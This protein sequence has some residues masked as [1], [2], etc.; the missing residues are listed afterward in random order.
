MNRIVLF[1]LAT[2]ALAA[3]DL[4]LM[5]QKFT[6]AP[7]EILMVSVHSGDAFPIS[8]DGA[9]PARLVEPRLIGPNGIA[10]IT[11]FRIAAK[12]THG[13]VPVDQQ[14]SL[15]LAV[16]TKPR[17]LELPAAKFESYLKEEGLDAVLKHR[18]G[19]SSPGRERYSKYAKSLLHA[20]APTPEFTAAP[21]GLPIEIVPLKD[22]AQLKPGAE[23]PL[24]ILFHGKPAAG[25][26]IVSAWAPPLGKSKHS[27]VGRTD[28]KGRIDIPLEAAGRWRIHAVHMQPC[29][30]KNEADWES[31]WAS[32]TF[33]LQ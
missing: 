15:W 19:S 26:Q 28:A 11:S 14:G 3:H 16:S 13:F 24:Q 12:A 30:D 20:G 9:D 6:A 5:P 17:L 25:L 18:A 2:A 21:L 8:V 22:P 31:F 27:I 7:G 29:P 4:Y 33:E 10:S 1:A 23:M 32:L